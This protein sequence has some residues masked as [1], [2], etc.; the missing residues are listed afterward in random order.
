MF[1]IQHVIK[2]LHQVSIWKLLIFGDGYD[3]CSLEAFLG[4]VIEIISNWYVCSNIHSP[5]SSHANYI[6]LIKFLSFV[7]TL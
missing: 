5:K 1:G 4:R 6:G 7:T 3:L 2:I